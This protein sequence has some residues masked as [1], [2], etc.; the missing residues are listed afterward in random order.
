MA[1][2]AARQIRASILSGEL[3]PG[4]RVRQEELADRLAV[5]RAPVRQALFILEREGL[6]HT[7][8]LRGRVVAPLD[9]KVIRDL[10]QL[11]G[12]IEREVAAILARDERFK[13]GPVRDIVTSGMENYAKGDRTRLIDLDLR[14]HTALYEAVGNRVLLEVMNT[15]WIHVRRVMAATLSM[16]GYPEQ[17]WTEHATILDAIEAHDPVLASDRA[18]AHAEA[19]SQRLLD[20]LHSQS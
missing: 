11:R 14:F 5:S 16:R 7:D 3:P 8:R 17:V 9:P 12:A 6:L 10:Y 18:A 4:T 1:E 20:N 15:Q 19:A 13:I 2:S